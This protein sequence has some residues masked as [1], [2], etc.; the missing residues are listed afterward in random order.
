[1]LGQ[2]YCPN[3]AGAIPDRDAPAIGTAAGDGAH[4]GCQDVQPCAEKQLATRLSA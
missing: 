2:Q 4:R 3:A 1:V